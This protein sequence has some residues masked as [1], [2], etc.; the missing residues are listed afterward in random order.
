MPAS[1]PS[2]GAPTTDLRDLATRAGERVRVGGLVTGAT[3]D[4]LRLDDGTATATLVLQGD[5]SDLAAL[6]TPGDALDAVGVVGRPQRGRDGQ[7]KRIGGGDRRVLGQL[8][9]ED[10]RLGGVGPA[11][12]L[13]EALRAT[14]EEVLDL[15]GCLVNVA[16]DRHGT[17][18]GYGAFLKLSAAAMRVLPPSMTS[19]TFR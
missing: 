18:R 15:P 8:A 4:G 10:L 17:V 12:H 6:V 9:D 19:R 13:S 7:Q 14:L 2:D 1:T 16:R 11:E 5:A 3:A